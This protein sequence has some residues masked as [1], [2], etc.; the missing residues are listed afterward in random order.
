MKDDKYFDNEGSYIDES[1]DDE[2]ISILD[3]LL[4]ENNR[5]PIK[6]Y[7]GNGNPLLMEQVAV[8]PRDS[9]LYV[10]LKPLQEMKG[11]AENEAIV[12]YVDDETL[13]VETD[14]DV[15]FDIFDKYYK[16]LEEAGIKKDDSDDDSDGDVDH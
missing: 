8:I 7:D 15:A 10:I 2:I 9:K 12:F 11:V 1:E 13:R 16:L 14:D 4:D 5:D 6:L 3:I